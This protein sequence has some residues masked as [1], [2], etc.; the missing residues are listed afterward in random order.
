MRVGRGP[1]TQETLVPQGFRFHSRSR[2]IDR[3]LVV[4]RSCRSFASYPLS[5]QFRFV[6]RVMIRR[7]RTE[8]MSQLIGKD[9]TAG[10]RSAWLVFVPLLA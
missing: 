7:L 5:L 9:G 4:R 6:G 10:T 1:G 8:I 3:S 2:S